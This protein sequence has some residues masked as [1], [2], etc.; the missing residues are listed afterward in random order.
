MEEGRKGGRREGTIKVEQLCGQSGVRL[1]DPDGGG[2]QW[3]FI[4]H[5]VFSGADRHS[6]GRAVSY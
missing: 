6:V 2:G 5:V 4:D 3:G 1:V